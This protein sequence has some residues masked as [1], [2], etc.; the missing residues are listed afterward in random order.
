MTKARLYVE[1]ESR[2]VDAIAKTYEKIDNIP[3]FAER[4]EEKDERTSEDP[5]GYN[6]K[7]EVNPNDPFKDGKEIGERVTKFIALCSSEL[8]VEAAQVIFGVELAALNTL[9]AKDCPIS[10]DVINAI[11]EKAFKYYTA[12]LSKIADPTTK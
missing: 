4:P 6:Q 3:A 7:K 10:E 8:N 12:S 11:R 5:F 9:N 2:Q 1:G